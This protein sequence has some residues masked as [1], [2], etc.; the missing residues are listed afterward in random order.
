MKNEEQIKELIH[1]AGNEICEYCDYQIDGDDPI[2][3]IILNV[4]KKAIEL[5]N[6]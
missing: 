5:Q 3:E 1:E 2:D 4:V 6:A